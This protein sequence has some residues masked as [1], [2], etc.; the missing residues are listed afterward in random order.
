MPGRASLVAGEYYAHPRNA[1]WRIIAALLPT[2]G[3]LASRPYRERVRALQRGEIALW[4]VLASCTRESNLDSDIDDS[5]IVPNDF[6][7]FFRDH[8]H[9]ERVFFNGAK[10]EQSYRRFVLPALP[11]APT[12]VYQRLPST[13]PA[14]AAMS[15]ERKL[16][17]WRVIAATT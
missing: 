4:D 17:A 13:S 6:P 8:P 12:L 11:D 15:F 14:H 5:S 16:E 3:D 2:S 10:A 9:I 7:G 1:F